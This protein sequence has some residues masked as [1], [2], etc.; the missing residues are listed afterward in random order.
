MKKIYSIPQTL[1]VKIAPA[2]M[3]ALSGTLD[4]DPSH[5]ITSSDDFGSR[6][7]SSIW[8]DEDDDDMND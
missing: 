3:I 8:D 2:K 4:N 7:S 6:R 1:V 5:S